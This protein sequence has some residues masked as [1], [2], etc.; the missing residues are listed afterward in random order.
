M[1][2]VSERSAQMTAT[3]TTWILGG[4]ALILTGVLGLLSSAFLG[5]STFLQTLACFTYL[6]AVLLFAFG[7]HPRAS[8]VDRRPL[9]MTAMLVFGVWPLLIQLIGLVAPMGAGGFANVDITVRLAS[10]TIAA[11]QIVRAGVVPQPWQ[12]APLWVLA[13]AAAGYFFQ[14]VLGVALGADLPASTDYVILLGYL[15]NLAGT[16]GLGIAALVASIR[17]NGDAT[18]QILKFEQT[19][20]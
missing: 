15:G 2:N 9:G 16:F 18:V 3:R 14:G 17:K 7:L 8:V 13:I 10:A 12:W 6:I 1:P 4:S 19:D 11:V 5:A 20:S